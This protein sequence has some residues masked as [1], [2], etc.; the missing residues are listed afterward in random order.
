MTYLLCSE[1]TALLLKMG[2][3]KTQQGDEKARVTAA[4]VEL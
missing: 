1:G 4:E 3:K 2:E